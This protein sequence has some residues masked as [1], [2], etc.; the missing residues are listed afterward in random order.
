M[1]R[2]R[3]MQTDIKKILKLHEDGKSGRWISREL[4]KHRKTVSEYIRTFKRLEITSKELEEK[5]DREIS[6]LFEEDKALDP[7]YEEFL[8]FIK[9]HIKDIN[10][11]GY[12]IQ[13][14]YEIYEEEHLEGYLR[15]Q[16]HFH[17]RALIKAEKGSFRIA[18]KYGDKLLIDFAGKH[19]EI[20]DKS[21]GEVKEVE[22]FVGILPASGYTYVEAVLNQGKESLIGVTSNCLTFMGGVPLSIVPDNLKSAVTKASKYEAVINKSFK[23]MGD[24]Y[25]TVINP[26]RSYKPKDKAMVEGAVKIIYIRIYYPI[27]HMTFFSLEELNKELLIQ[28]ELYNK[29]KLSNRD[30]SRLDLYNEEKPHLKPLPRDKFELWEYKRA[31]IQKMGYVLLSERKNYYSVPYRFIGKRVELRYN[32][33]ILEVHYS[34]QRIAIHKISYAKGHYTTIKDHLCSANQHYLDWSPS[35]FINKGAKVGEATKSYI[36]ELILQAQYPEA[37]YK[38]S[39]GILSMEKAYGS[40]RLNKACEL[41]ARHQK[42]SYYMVKQILVNETDKIWQEEE[43]KIIPMHQNIRGANKYS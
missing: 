38:Q 32:T 29:R 31:K 41:G 28:L 4:D 2:Q 12:T 39:L 10:R 27:R 18:H 22:V 24:H 6:D 15:S 11:P 30:E 7:K 23:D 19:L 3:I 43:P 1:S 25:D 35:F 36:E 9:L 26:T 16:F 33:S 40:D 20:V 13:N 21:T 34:S 5:T 14:L 17:Y 37:A 42:H 8:R